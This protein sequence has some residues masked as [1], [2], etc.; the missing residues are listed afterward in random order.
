M[1]SA[2]HT[3]P[4]FSGAVACVWQADALLGEG[5]V[6]VEETQSL[7]WVD[8]KGQRIHRLSL[9]DGR[10]TTWEIGQAVGSLAQRREGGFIIAAQ[11]GFQLTDAEFGQ[12][13]SLGHPEARLPTNRFNDGKCDAQGR[14]W[15]GT[16]D[17]HERQ[18]TGS[19][20]RLDAD[21]T[22]STMDTGYVVTNG[23]AFSPDG[24]TLYHTDTFAR[25]IYAFD[26]S[27][28]GSLS[29][30]RPHIR[31]PDDEGYPDGMTVDGLGRLWVA[32][33]GGWRVSCFAPDGQPLGH[34]RLPV[35]QVTSCA[36]GGPDMESLYITSASVGLSADERR[37]QPLAGGLLAVPVAVTGLAPGRFAG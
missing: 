20:Y 27:T 8:I 25:T 3:A 23:P 16:M 15:A 26:L 33:W 32:H 21:G 14:F 30:K 31:I 19:L 7:Y 22:C 5:P 24:S 28:D 4:N 9:P 6:W 18:P 29:A 35:A 1:S 11:D 17:N 36:F 13:R 10:R 37:L 34:V 12:R 2:T